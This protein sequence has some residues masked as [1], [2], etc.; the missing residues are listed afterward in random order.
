MKAIALIDF[1]L[2][3]EVDKIRVEE[4]PQSSFWCLCDCVEESSGDMIACIGK[5]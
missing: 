1:I 2:L 5:S 4:K 3:C